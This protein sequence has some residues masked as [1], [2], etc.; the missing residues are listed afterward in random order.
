MKYLVAVLTLSMLATASA[1]SQSG[2]MIQMQY[3]AG[4]QL[5]NIIQVGG[6]IGTDETVQPL[7]FRHIS[8]GSARF[9]PVDT[10]VTDLLNTSS[11]ATFDIRLEMHMHHGKVGW[12]N[13]A[14]ITLD[15]VDARTGAIRERIFH[16]RIDIGGRDNDTTL[17]W[18]RAVDLGRYQGEQVYAMIRTDALSNAPT[19][20][21]VP[22]NPAL[23]NRELK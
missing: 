8:V 6:V 22:Y 9:F 18:R 20:S 21:Y 2:Q 23:F 1:F 3:V 16:E 11:Q 15:I 12:G 14:G 5:K 7:A 19:T 10:C 4:L 17:A 13:V